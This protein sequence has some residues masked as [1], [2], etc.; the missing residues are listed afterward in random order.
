MIFKFSK[1][2]QIVRRKNTTGSYAD[3]QPHFFLS[4][5]T[6]STT[7]TIAPGT[8]SDIKVES[9]KAQ[10]DNV[11]SGF[12]LKLFQ[13][14]N[15]APDEVIRVRCFWLFFHRSEIQIVLSAT[16]HWI[17]H[18]WLELRGIVISSRMRVKRLSSYPEAMIIF[19]IVRSVFLAKWRS[20]VSSFFG[21]KLFVLCESMSFSGHMP[22][23]TSD[24]ALTPLRMNNIRGYTAL[25]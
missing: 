25:I 9:K 6:T 21:P 1:A 24:I 10:Q 18:L 7:H 4:Y 11:P 22:A 23:Y 2:R 12:I 16:F 13:M 15:G 14:V 3:S 8:M 5:K 19:C 20:G 17:L